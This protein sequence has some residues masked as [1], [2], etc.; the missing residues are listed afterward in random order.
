MERSPERAAPFCP[1]FGTCGGCAAQ[2]MSEALYRA[3][4]RGLVVKALAQREHQR[5]SRAAD[6]RAWR[7]PA[8]GDLSRPLSAWVSGRGRLHAGALA[9]HRGDRRLPAVR[10]VRWLARLP[11]R[12]PL[13]ATCAGWQTPR[14]RRDRDQRWSRRRSARRRPARARRDAQTRPHRRGA[15]SR[16]RSNH[17]AVVVERRPPRVAFGD[18]LVTLPAGGFLQATEEG[19]ASARGL[20]RGCAQGREEGCGPLLRRRRLCPPSR[21]NARRFAA[22]SDAAAI[23]ALSGP[24]AKRAGLRSGHGRDARSFPPA[25]CA[26]RARCVSTAC[27]SIRRAP[28]RKRRRAKSRRA[29]CRLSSPSPATSRPSLATRESSIDGGF[30]ARD[31]HRR[32]TSSAFRPMS[33][34]PPSFADARRRRA[35]GGFSDDH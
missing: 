28:G 31:R 6:R 20:R 16:P 19:E 11:R 5:R 34:S 13:R 35:R 23:A 18:T 33:K 10:A 2:H 14:H 27:C 30:R 17:G 15:R 8:P 32:L 25:A 3:W 26:P 21:P 7:G 1:W 9:R 4:K 12:G 29:A 22:D 24:R